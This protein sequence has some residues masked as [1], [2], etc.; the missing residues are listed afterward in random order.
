MT[1]LEPHFNPSRDVKCVKYDRAIMWFIG[2][3][4]IIIGFFD[5]FYTNGTLA[6][7]KRVNINDR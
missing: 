1:I 7:G 2:L 6:S 3:T 4:L 5:L